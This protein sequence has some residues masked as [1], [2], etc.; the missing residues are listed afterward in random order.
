MSCNKIVRKA[1]EEIV[2][3]RPLYIRD[4]INDIDLSA[5]QWLPTAFKSIVYFLD[6]RCKTTKNQ[7]ILR[8]LRTEITTANKKFSGLYLELNDC[9][10]CYKG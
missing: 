2:S 7:Y 6:V 4:L 5:D 3:C 10:K 9:C 8:I 1:A